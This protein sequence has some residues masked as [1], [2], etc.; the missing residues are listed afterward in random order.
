[1]DGL[2]PIH[3]NIGEEVDEVHVRDIRGKKPE[4][5]RTLRGTRAQELARDDTV[6]CGTVSAAGKFLG[7]QTE[8]W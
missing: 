1:M 7:M 2:G 5:A 6:H 3:V 4:K 8:S